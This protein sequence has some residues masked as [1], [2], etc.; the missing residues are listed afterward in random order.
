MISQDLAHLD[1]ELAEVEMERL[2][3]TALARFPGTK[4]VLLECTNLPPYK[5]V[6][7]RHF[8]G[9]IHDCLTTLEGVHS[10]LV[11]ERFLA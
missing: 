6:I 5:H 11:K 8:A 1:F 2:V 3:A 10:G 9:E 4:A 7:R